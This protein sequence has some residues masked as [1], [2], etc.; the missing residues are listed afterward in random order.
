MTAN[1]QK[2]VVNIVVGSHSMVPYAEKGWAYQREMELFVES[3]ISNAAVI[4]AATLQNARFFRID[5]QL[6]S[7]EK[8]KLAD[9]ILV[10]GNP[11]ENIKAMRDIQKV[12][13]NGTWVK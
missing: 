8:G 4:Q 13:I 12:M 11:L 5:K 2:G 9:L 7:I 1:L 3:G 10:K 6:G